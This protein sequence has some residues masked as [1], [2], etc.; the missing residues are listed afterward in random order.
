MN[1]NFCIEQRWEM[2]HCAIRAACGGAT[3]PAALLPVTP[4]RGDSE[5][6]SLFCK[7]ACQLEKVSP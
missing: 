3:F 2:A 4:L 7:L 1:T 6:F 5:F